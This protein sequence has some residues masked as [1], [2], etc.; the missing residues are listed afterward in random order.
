MSGSKYY[1]VQELVEAAAAVLESGLVPQDKKTVSEVPDERTVRYYLS[2][3]LIPEAKMEG[4]VKLF[5]DLHLFALLAIKKFQS[6][7][8]PINIIRSLIENRSE[9]ELK[10]WLGEELKVFTD[11]TSLKK[12]LE[13][14][15]GS[16]KEEVVVIND[17]SARALFLGKAGKNDAQNYLESLL[18]SRKK[19]GRPIP[20]ASQSRSRSY[21]PPP[22]G[23]PL[24]LNDWRRYELAP[25]LELH[26]EQGYKPAAD[27]HERLS[28]I[29]SIKRILRSLEKR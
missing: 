19:P 6:D 26:V 28:I 27:E 21:H 12:H 10:R 20:D 11:E 9:A 7:G 24:R 8:L 3:G 18:S 16:E 15:E 2:E 23:R 1:G 17:P 29:D 22:T 25:G 5:T 13:G 14:H 4:R